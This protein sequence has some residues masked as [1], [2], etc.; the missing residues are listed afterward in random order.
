MLSPRDCEPYGNGPATNGI[1]TKLVALS[2]IVYYIS[3]MG[4]NMAERRR[5]VP[6]RDSIHAE[7]RRV[8]SETGI[9][10]GKIIEFA[11]REWLDARERAIEPKSERRPS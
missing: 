11:V 3:H 7:V 8:K 10:I 9:S 6:L 4:A 5:M 2:T 1:Y